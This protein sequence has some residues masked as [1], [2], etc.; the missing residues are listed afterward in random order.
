[1][2]PFK[3]TPLCLA[4]F[5]LLCVGGIRS[6]A[7][8]ED[9]PGAPP[10]NTAK[11]F[12]RGDCNGDGAFSLSDAIAHLV[13]Q[14]SGGFTPPCKAACDANGDG[15]LTISDPIYGL[16]HLFLGSASPPAPYPACGLWNDPAYEGFYRALSCEGSPCP[17]DCPPRPTRQ[18]LPVTIRLPRPVVAAG[19]RGVSVSLE[20]FH[21]RGLQGDPRLPARVYSIVLPP[22]AD[23]ASVEVKVDA[24]ESV[25]SP[26][27]RIEPVGDWVKFIE[28]EGQALIAREDG[29][30]L[31][32][33]LNPSIYGVDVSYPE[34]MVG[35]SK[36]RSFRGWKVL[37]VPV[38]PVQ[39]NDAQGT[40]TVAG[41]VSLTVSYNETNNDSNPLLISTG[42]NTMNHLVVAEG[43][44]LWND[45][46]ESYDISPDAGE[47]SGD[48]DYVI[49]TEDSIY[50]EKDENG[51][52]AF[53]D[54]RE[55]LGHKVKV[56]VTG[57]IYRDYSAAD[58][59]KEIKEFLED[60]YERYGIKYVLLVGN[61]DPRADGADAPIADYGIVPMRECT[62]SDESSM[63]D[64]YYADFDADWDDDS[65][66]DGDGKY[67]ENWDET[68]Y[69]DVLVGRVA[70]MGGYIDD[71]YNS[72]GDVIYSVDRKEKLR[73]VFE[74]IIR[75]DREIDKSWR[76]NML[77]TGSYMYG[78]KG[79]TTA[80]T[81]T[82]TISY[83]H[84][85][86]SRFSAYTVYQNGE[87][88]GLEDE[89]FDGYSNPEADAA[90]V[91][92]GTL[93]DTST[94]FYAWSQKKLGMVFWRG[95]GGYTSVTVGDDLKDDDEDT[96]DGNM[97]QRGWILLPGGYSG[98]ALENDYPA[99]VS[100]ASCNNFSTGYSSYGS[101]TQVS[102]WAS[103]AQTL[104]YRGAICV[105]AATNTTA[106][107]DPCPEDPS[108][109][110]SAWYQ[111]EFLRKLA[112]GWTFGHAYMD[113]KRQ[114]QL[115]YES[116]HKTELQDWLR[117][118]LLGDPAQEFIRDTSDFPDDDFDEGTGNDD[119]DHASV[120]HTGSYVSDPFGTD[121]LVNVNGAVSKDTDCYVLNDLGTQLKQVKVTVNRNESMGD[122]G[123]KIINSVNLK[124]P[125]TETSSDLERTLT[126][127]SRSETIYILITTGT[128]VIDY[129]MSVEVDDE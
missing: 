98:Y 79:G 32:D 60:C 47:P 49:V 61:P 78:T 12:I 9:C 16:S 124:V 80:T 81:L 24:V 8:A 95:H 88:F 68:G 106:S 97:I 64:M 71:V 117:I 101:Y 21:P 87:A 113:G 122:V 76:Y 127:S 38:S 65:G 30:Q 22:T 57:D 33:G 107:E 45:V 66:G 83:I 105:V 93:G 46:A 54:H 48:Y 53:I 50:D 102:K 29:L 42:S 99:V 92:S 31:Q 86:D 100:S 119:K 111:R 18:T 41:S 118:N 75:Y 126:V 13:F 115:A 37:A 104:H 62:T 63:T 108:L 70:P 58:E 91:G 51:L 1:M 56:G 123:I 82:K 17:S 20:G 129:D 94:A 125:G 10:E 34:S 73:A 103:L 44:Q 120:I 90:L 77:A 89:W 121:L 110:Q 35:P 6:S 67:A 85:D 23:P 14:F 59:Q 4:A 74:K 3:K 40:L 5:T 112:Q 116:N 36:V 2:R 28:D 39:Y 72:D 128:H 7:T 114:V 25:V 15:S 109:G 52:Q 55:L 84:G 27:D 19:P 96:D 69:P 11:P 26:V 43:L